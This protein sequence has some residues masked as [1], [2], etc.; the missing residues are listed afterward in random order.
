MATSFVDLNS[1][2]DLSAGFYIEW[3]ERPP[4]FPPQPMVPVA[5]YDNALCVYDFG[6]FRVDIDVQG[7]PVV[8]SACDPALLVGSF[9][10]GD[11]VL[12]GDTHDTAIP[13]RLTLTPSVRAIGT[14][15]AAIGP[16]GS[17]YLA[18]VKARDATTGTWMSRVVEGTVSLD[19]ESAPFIGLRCRN[20]GLIDQ[21]SFDVASLTPGVQFTQVAINQLFCVPKK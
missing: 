13:L 3:A 12:L 5:P 6:D 14:R 8:L 2:D 20:G 16:P 10:P 19:D 15:V 21:V 4:D 11:S 7:P 1:P 9:A 17:K 18:T